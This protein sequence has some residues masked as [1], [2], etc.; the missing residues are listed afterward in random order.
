MYFAIESAGV[1]LPGLI[2]KI[3]LWFQV[4]FGIGFLIF[5][6]ELG[7]FL[8]AKKIGVRVETFSLG[9]GPRLFGFKKGETDYRF[10]LVPLGGY[11]KMAGENP[12]DSRTDAPDELQNRS[13]SERLIIFSAGVIL[14]FLFAFIAIPIIFAIGIP[15]ITPAVGDVRPGGPAWKAGLETGDTILQI[16]GN[17]I[18][19]FNDVPLNIALGR[20]GS[21][22][23]LIERDGKTFPVDVVP[24]MNEQA[25]RYQIQISPPTRYLVTVEKNSP[26]ARAGLLERD[27]VISINGMAPGAWRASDG[28]QSP[29]S[30]SI[31]VARQ[32]DE[33]EIN[34]T[35]LLSPEE[36]VT[37][38]RYLIGVI[39]RFNEVLALR[40]EL[41]RYPGGIEEG[42]SLLV[43]NGI[44]IFLQED[45]ERALDANPGEAIPI[46][47]E[48]KGVKVDLLYG[49]DWRE[50]LKEDMAV[51]LNLKTNS[52]G[53]LPGGALEKLH[54]PAVRNGMRILAV[55]G[56]KT[57]TMVDIM[58]VISQASSSEFRITI[59]LPGGRGEKTLAFQAEPLR[60]YD[61]GLQFLFDYQVR[62]LNI[63]DAIKAGFHCALNMVRS[64]YLTV[65]RMLTGDVGSKNLGGILAIGDASYSFA[66]LGLARLFYFLAILSINLGF[67][68][69]L[70]IPILDGG[71]IL[72]L[73]IEKIKGS[74]VSE[75]VM[76]YSQIAGLALVL[77]LLIYV[78]WNDILR[79][80][81]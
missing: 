1:D 48:R 27:R 8:A 57:D 16:N 58:R 61:L 26:A 18:Y 52:V 25:G 7:H 34:R 39:K 73:L 28:G 10:S 30:L 56:E 80:I 49:S 72:F 71:H 5:I 62:K 59:D 35:I 13:V 70:P 67:L 43:M 64:C 69:I 68:N 3:W 65:S 46:T 54:D 66:K 50:R 12:D 32:T 15:I 41:A 9:F 33:G 29:A 77:L 81:A 74:P 11:V 36:I 44:E 40:R 79:L 55:N 17:T 38:D 23:L 24:K 51:T 47:V 75:R 19:E 42:D 78:T 31:E 20:P 37:E 2:E 6:H 22:R 45:L 14:N 21:T 63:P 60:R 4:V 53:V 76:G